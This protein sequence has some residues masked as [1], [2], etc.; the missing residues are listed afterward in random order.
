VWKQNHLCVEK[1]SA[2]GNCWLNTKFVGPVVC[3]GGGKKTAT[4]A[5]GG[6][7]VN[8][9]KKLWRD[10][11]FGGKEYTERKKPKVVLNMEI[12]GKNGPKKTCLCLGGDLFVV[13]VLL[14]KGKEG[15]E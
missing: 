11:V 15:G 8:K 12:K 2:G 6:L 13:L 7:I 1:K 3:R 5:G 4:H 14:E 9:K 10:T